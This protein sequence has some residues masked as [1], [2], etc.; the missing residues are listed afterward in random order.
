VFTSVLGLV[1]VSHLSPRGLGRFICITCSFEQSLVS[2]LTWIFVVSE[3][4]IRVERDTTLYGRLNEEVGHLGGVTKPHDKSC[5]S[6]VLDYCDCYCSSYSHYF[7]EDFL[8][9]FWCVGFAKFSFQIYF[10]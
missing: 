1:I 5:V 4:R 10:L 9:I 3:G 8:I 6:Y 7:V 2:D